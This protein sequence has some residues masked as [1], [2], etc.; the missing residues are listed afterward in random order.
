MPV[1]R[2]Y[3]LKDQD[4]GQKVVEVRVTGYA[5]QQI[6][7]LNKGTAFSEEERRT[8]ELDGLLPSMIFD[9]ETQKQRVYGQYSSYAASFE[10]YR[11]L[12]ELQDTNETLFYALL[13]EHLEEML[14]IIYT[15]TVGQAAQEYSEIFQ[16]P[17]G[18]VVSTAT[19]DNVVNAL[20]NVPLDDVRL[21]VATDSSAVL[22]IGDQGFGGMAIPIG[23]LS[24]YT[25][26]GGVGPD[27]TLP[28][29]LDVGTDRDDLLANP[30]YLGVRHRRLADANYLAFMDRFVEAIAARYPGLI[31]QWEDFGRDRAFTVLDRYRG[32]IASFN[33][34]IQGTGAMALAGVLSACKQTNTHLR[35][36]R[37]VVL[38][39][40]AGGI[41][42]VWALTQGMLRQ[43]L[44]REEV[45]D[46]ILVMD[47][48]GIL[49]S[50]R[51]ME[52]FKRPYAQEASRL[53]WAYSGKERLLDVVRNTGATVLLGLSGRPN[54]F[55]EEIVA[56]M[57]ANTERPIIFPLSNP[58]ASSEARP[59][60]LLHWSRG[61]AIVATGSPFEAVV[62]DGKVHAI[63][64]GNNAFIFPGLGFGAL[65]AKVTA[66]TDGMVLAAAD[67]LAAY[68]QRADDRVFPS[69]AE[70]GDVAVHV[71]AAVIQQAVE[72]GVASE[73]R[74]AGMSHEEL[75]AYVREM[76]WVP[77]YLPFVRADAGR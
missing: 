7:L 74:V 44:T 65:L 27:R 46:R 45:R 20:A 64:Q 75:L 19:I 49:T 15:P 67:A 72:D 59:A 47:S 43:G 34:D 41:G 26:A 23:K 53:A 51:D 52:W 28:I 3:D 76:K 77:E 63:G 68:T 32:R 5:L 60:D 12:R 4:D 38:G 61:K 69:V 24:I 36:Q 40:G 42:V 58:T 62:A 6:P 18:F 71:A 11:F 25:A 10:R 2:Y 57:C 9:I 17:R 66:V 22:G 48:R 50:D 35:D 29:E 13:S 37:V 30:L 16:L 39:A 33:D 73:Q 14:P 54:A 1:S 8:L 21:A 56:S 31:L 55:D 70:M